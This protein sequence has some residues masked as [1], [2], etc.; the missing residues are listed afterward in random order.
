MK[1]HKAVRNEEISV[2]HSEFYFPFFRFV[3]SGKRLLL[4]Q[5][6]KFSK[7]QSKKILICLTSR[8]SMSLKYGKIMSVHYNDLH[9]KYQLKNYTHVS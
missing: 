6:I 7:T 9:F 1:K 8:Y 5:G 3:K 4:L 2:T